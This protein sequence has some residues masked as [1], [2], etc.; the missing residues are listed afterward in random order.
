M[1]CENHPSRASGKKYE[2][3]T[4]DKHPLGLRMFGNQSKF[5]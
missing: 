2:L 3:A 5:G 4:V 1:I